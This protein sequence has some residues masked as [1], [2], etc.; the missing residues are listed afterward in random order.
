MVG[1]GRGLCLG[2]ECVLGGV[3]LDLFFFGTLGWMVS[4]R[5]SLILLEIDVDMLTCTPW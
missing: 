3:G 2:T 5:A 1:C 4:N